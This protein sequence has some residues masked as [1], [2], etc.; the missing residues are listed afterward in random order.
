MQRSG[1]TMQARKRKEI[2]KLTGP[3]QR[4]VSQ[5]VPQ[6]RESDV[7]EGCEYDDAGDVEVAGEEAIAFVD[8]A[9]KVRPFEI[10]LVLLDGV[11]EAGNDGGC[12]QKK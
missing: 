11:E 10:G 6:H 4:L 7:A 3:D 5:P 9:D 2:G 1:I 12:C 8:E